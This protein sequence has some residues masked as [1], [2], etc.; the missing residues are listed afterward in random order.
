MDIE[1]SEIKTEKSLGTPINIREMRL[2]D[3]KSLHSMYDSLPDEDKRFFHPG[4]LGYKSIS[5]YWLLFQPILV[6][7]SFKSIRRLL[8]VLSP[9]VFLPLV[10]INKKGMVVG[11]AYLKINRRLR[12]GC[13]HSSLGIVVEKSSR[14]IGLG[15]ELMERLLELAR[16]EKI[17]EIYL[18]VHSDNIKA[19]RLYKKHG[20][21]EVGEILDWWKGKPFLSKVMKKVVGKD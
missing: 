8:L 1:N 11:F 20:F 9:I 5:F 12:N 7:S 15:S 17:C 18:T 16:K 2:S 10:A 21:Q 19:I 14:G 4:F 3:L 6:L 13:L